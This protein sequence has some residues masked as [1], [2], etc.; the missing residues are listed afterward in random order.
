MELKKRLGMIDVFCIASGAMISSGIFVL[1]GLAY[2]RAGPSVVFSYLLAGVLAATGLLSTAELATAMPKAGSDYYFITR[3]MGPAIG[4]MAGVLNWVS[5]SLKSAFALVGMA[6]VIRLVLP[7]DIRV[8]GVVLGIVF[9]GV[10]LVGVKAAARLQVALVLGLLGLMVVYI[11]YG[12]PAVSFSNYEPLAPRGMVS[13]FS[14]AGFVFVAYGGLLKVA[15]VAEEVRNPG[16]TIPAGM[17]LSLVLIGICYAFMVAVTVGVV[18]ADVLR[19]S[20]T[21][22]AEGASAVMGR[23][24]GVAMGVAASLAFLTTANAG[25]LAGSRYLLALSRDGVL[26]PSV[27]A[28]GARFHTPYVAVLVTGC[29]VILPLFVNL[30]ILVESAS[31]GLILTNMLALLSVIVLRESLLQ[32]YRPTFRAPLYPWLQLAGLAGFVF[33]ILEMRE[34]VYAISAL[35]A[36]A[37]FCVYWFYGRARVQRQSAL[38][39]VLQRLTARELVDGALDAELKEVVRERDEIVVDRFDGIIERCPVLD[40]D[41]PMERDAFFAEAAEA[42]AVRLGFEEDPLRRL[43]SA[44]E[45]Q[46]ST[47][48]AP[49]LAVPH[50]VVEGTDA[51]EILLGR[52]KQ[53]I[54]FSD[55]NAIVHTVI[56]LAGPPQ[57][58]NFHLR[59]LAAIA[60]VCQSAEFEKR[61]LEAPGEQALRDLF[62]LSRRQRTDERTLEKAT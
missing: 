31:I 22:I 47:V 49:H 39:H 52:C 33:V 60:Q 21:P 1:P 9:V 7:I 45:E 43:L 6:A 25:I 16:R 29:C 41:G 37:G 5:F 34:E 14:T 13:V 59:C 12:L 36:M 23:A 11:L 17:I 32:N 8:S 18:E 24:G 30:R 44:R 20:L 57:E 35:L 50:I 27:G 56:V 28:V 2:D 46:S 42:L 38:L 15:S 4:T 53:G 26:P 19:G 61:W 51:F 40:L 55:D 58:R 48:L 54:R 10:N 3:A 62:V